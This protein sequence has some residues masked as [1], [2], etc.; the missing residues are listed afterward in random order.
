MFEHPVFPKTAA[1]FLGQEAG[2]E[3]KPLHSFLS[4]KNTRSAKQELH[5]EGT[6]NCPKAT[7]LQS[8]VI[9]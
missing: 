6:H 9:L 2:K 4:R 3:T 1:S 7:F 8:L 5:Y